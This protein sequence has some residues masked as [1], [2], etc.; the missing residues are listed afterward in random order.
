VTSCIQLSRRG[1]DFKISHDLGTFNDKN[2]F[3]DEAAAVTVISLKICFEMFDY[4]PNQ[5]KPLI[6][7]NN[8]TTLIFA[9]LNQ[10]HN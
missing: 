4:Q 3:V 2:N 8:G 7:Y 1:A 10:S 9:R 5:Y 6:H